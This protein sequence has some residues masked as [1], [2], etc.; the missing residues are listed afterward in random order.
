MDDI[1]FYHDINITKS[2]I[3]QSITIDQNQEKT[4]VFV[5]FEN[6]TLDINIDIMSSANLTI[7]MFLYGTKSLNIVLNH[8]GH[9]SRS[10]TSITCV[11]KNHDAITISANSKIAYKTPKCDVYESIKGLLFTG[12]SI[13][14]E[15][16]LSIEN[17]DCY[18]KHAST[19]GSI[20]ESVLF[21]LMSRGIDKKTAC[22]MIIVSSFNEVVQG[23]KEDTIR[24]MENRINEL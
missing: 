17:N 3:H 10:N 13:S 21:Y 1:T 14:V 4:I 22:N 23:L 5:L 11:A 18:A 6:N 9:E 12:G 2:N 24:I 19:I 15:P 16:K 20:D 8:L 7:R